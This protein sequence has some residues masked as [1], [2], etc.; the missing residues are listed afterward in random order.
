MHNLVKKLERTHKKK[1]YFEKEYK[2]EQNPNIVYKKNT[3][4]PLK[5]YYA[6]KPAEIK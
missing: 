2:N 6:Q 5:D 4:T 3:Q 1:A